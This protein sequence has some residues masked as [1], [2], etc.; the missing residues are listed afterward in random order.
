VL[1][2]DPRRQSVRNIS[3]WDVNTP[4]GE[5]IPPIVRFLLN[6][7]EF[8]VNILESQKPSNNFLQLQGGGGA[9]SSGQKRNSGGATMTTVAPSGSFG[10]FEQVISKEIG[11]FEG[12]FEISFTSNHKFNRGINNKSGKLT[13]AFDI[14]HR[15]CEEVNNRAGS[16][17]RL[18]TIL[19]RVMIQYET[20]ITE[21]DGSKI[22]VL[23]NSL[24]KKKK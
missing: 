5:V 13:D 9:T 22:E 2:G 17:G 21:F 6:S 7:N 16:N 1:N 14:N 18:P 10:I 12:D 23:K 8:Y 4:L 15:I 24:K 19:S 11:N 20:F 3:G